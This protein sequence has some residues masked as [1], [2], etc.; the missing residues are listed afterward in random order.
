MI[1]VAYHNAPKEQKKTVAHVRSGKARAKAIAAPK[2]EGDDLGKTTGDV[3]LLLEKKYHIMEQFAHRYMPEIAKSVETA[4]E[5]QL[6]NLLLGAPSNEV[7]YDEANSQIEHMFRNFIDMRELDGTPGVP[8]LAAQRGVS[9]RFKHPYKRRPERSS[10][11][12]TGLYEASMTAE[13]KE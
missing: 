1:D 13:I 2:P 4:L 11:V 6:Q 7:Q 9:H 10:F 5:G 3:A 12:D 8:T